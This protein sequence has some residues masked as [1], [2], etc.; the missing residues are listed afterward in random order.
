MLPC[1]DA[2]IENGSVILSGPNKV[3]LQRIEKHYGQTLRDNFPFFGVKTLIFKVFSEER[4]KKK[5]EDQ[6]LQDQ[7]QRQQQKE[8]QERILAEKQQQEAEL[9]SLPLKK[10]IRCDFKSIPPANREMASLDEF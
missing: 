8:Q 2:E 1:L 9:N 4:Q 5:D 7:I 10:T 3:A 6:K